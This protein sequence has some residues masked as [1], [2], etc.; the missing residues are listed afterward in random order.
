MHFINESLAACVW[1]GILNLKKKTN[2]CVFTYQ[3]PAW[4]L[5]PCKWLYDYH[6]HGRETLWSIFSFCTS[7][8]TRFHFFNGSSSSSSFLSFNFLRVFSPYYLCACCPSSPATPTGSSRLNAV[9]SFLFSKSILPSR[10][11][12]NHTQTTRKLTNTLTEKKYES[13][14]LWYVNQWMVTLEG[15]C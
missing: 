6:W 4:A 10:W 2:D 15:G 11:K 12:Y 14:L 8:A 5:V 7:R 13:T 3:N 9:E 1:L